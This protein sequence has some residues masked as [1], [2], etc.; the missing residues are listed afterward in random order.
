M[1]VQ[2]KAQQRL[3]YAVLSGKSDAVPKKVAKEFVQHK[4]AKNLPERKGGNKRASK[5]K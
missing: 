3:M 4:A 2:S 1:P 5:R